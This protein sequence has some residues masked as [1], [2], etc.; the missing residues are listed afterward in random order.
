MSD[1][2]LLWQGNK[3]D[4]AELAAR[5]AS[6]A[7]DTLVQ[8]EIAS[9]LTLSSDSRLSSQFVSE[10]GAAMLVGLLLAASRRYARLLAAIDRIS[11]DAPLRFG[12]PLVVSDCDPLLEGLVLSGDDRAEVARSGDAPVGGGADC[13]TRNEARRAALRTQTASLMWMLV[14]ALSS[15]PPGQALHDALRAWPTASPAL[16]LAEPVQLPLVLRTGASE[17]ST[18]IKERSLAADTAPRLSAATTPA[19]DAPTSAIS[20]ATFTT[21]V[22]SADDVTP[23]A[24]PIV[25]CIESCTVPAEEVKTA[26]I[27]EVPTAIKTT[28]SDA[29]KLDWPTTGSAIVLVDVD[30][31]DGGMSDLSTPRGDDQDARVAV[32]SGSPRKRSPPE[33]RAHMQAD[34]AFDSATQT[35]GGVAGFN[36]WCIAMASCRSDSRRLQASSPVTFSPPLR[37]LPAWGT[38]QAAFVATLESY[39]A[40]AAELGATEPPMQGQPSRWKQARVAATTQQSLPQTQSSAEWPSLLECLRGVSASRAG[41]A[42]TDAQR[43]RWRS[44]LATQHSVLR[45]VSGAAAAAAAAAEATGSIGVTAD[46]LEDVRMSAVKGSSTVGAGTPSLESVSSPSPSSRD[47][48]GGTLELKSSP[49]SVITAALAAARRGVIA[50]RS[51][52]ALRHGARAKAKAAGKGGIDRARATHGARAK[53][54]A[55]GKGGIDRARATANVLNGPFAPPLALTLALTALRSTF[56]P[57]VLHYVMILSYKK[58]YRHEE[59]AK[60]R[61]MTPTPAAPSRSPET[62]AAAVVS[63]ADSVSTER[64]VGGVQTTI[65]VTRPLDDGVARV[66]ADVQYTVEQKVTGPAMLSEASSASAADEIPGL[67]QVQQ[68]GQD[69]AASAVESLAGRA[70]LAVA[71]AAA[72]ART[73]V[74]VR[75][76]ATVAVPAATPARPTSGLVQIQKKPRLTPISSTESV[77]AMPPRA[78]PTQVI[79]PLPR[80][81][82]VASLAAPNAVTGSAS[83]LKMRNASSGNPTPGVKRARDAPDSVAATIGKRRPEQLEAPSDSPTSSAE[84][85]D[86]SVGGTGVDDTDAAAR[87]VSGKARRLLGP[88]SQEALKAAE[89]ESRRSAKQ[90]RRMAAALAGSGVAPSTGP[91]GAHASTAAPL[92]GADKDIASGCWTDEE[93]AEAGTVSKAPS[94]ATGRHSRGRETADTDRYTT[95]KGSGGTARTSAE[96]VSRGSTAVSD[97]NEVLKNVGHFTEHEFAPLA[98][99]TSRLQDPGT[100]MQRLQQTPGPSWANQTWR[101]VGSEVRSTTDA[102]CLPPLPPAPQPLRFA[103]SAEPNSVAATKGRR[104]RFRGPQAAARSAPPVPVVPVHVWAPKAAKDS[105]SAGISEATCACESCV[106]RLGRAVVDVTRAQSPSLATVGVAYSWTSGTRAALEDPVAPTS[107]AL[108]ESKAELVEAGAFAHSEWGREPGASP[109]S[110]HEVRYLGPSTVVNAV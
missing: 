97:A 32:D 82:A 70:V 57:D 24:V 42:V 71:E 31:I 78:T 49:L 9:R 59:V 36:V 44:V 47:H 15:L 104:V 94:R 105:V 110:F 108:I 81:S 35:L 16:P 92:N 25:S 8:M 17:S 12:C 75:P 69:P 91:S 26:A 58:E 14:L 72:A 5:L 90:A 2:P 93:D 88:L 84:G 45:A 103:P 96:S 64:C 107:I 56:P 21:A 11:S 68:K 18:T 95:G 63:E 109:N 54:K 6:A 33:R 23:A 3:E 61:A 62:V 76:S 34:E 41:A 51:R 13:V 38:L 79:T 43:N 67:L 4:G 53:A 22:T 106:Q 29:L 98:S 50:A 80:K 100:L 55:A 46:A 60:L 73:S 65:N 30:D 87:P 19:S 99:T 66:Q 52:S 102:K 83:A 86:I 48:G 77:S 40:A 89:R 101:E 7:G 1:P 10:G 85:D 74:A 20:S 39:A 27:G 28:A 37:C